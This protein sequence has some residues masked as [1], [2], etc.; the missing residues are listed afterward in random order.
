MHATHLCVNLNART[1][2]TAQ[3]QRLGNL[4]SISPRLPKPFSVMQ[5][6]SATTMLWH[7]IINM[8]VLK[9]ADLQ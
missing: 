3:F 1:G 5:I 2:L 9:I 6:I 8:A 4:G 7:H